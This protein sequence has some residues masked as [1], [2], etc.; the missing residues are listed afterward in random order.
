MKSSTQFRRSSLPSFAMLL[1]SQE[2]AAL[3]LQV[4]DQCPHLIAMASLEFVESA[5][6][7]RNGL[8]VC[9]VEVLIDNKRK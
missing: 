6:T 2:S 3:L 8:E 9:K 1:E 7:L 4:C 5:R